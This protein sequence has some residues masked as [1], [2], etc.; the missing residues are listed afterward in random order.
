MDNKQEL[1]TLIYKCPTAYSVESCKK[2]INYFEQNIGYA[3]PGTLGARKFLNNLELSILIESEKD[4]FNLG[5]AIKRGSNG[6][7]KKYKLFDNDIDAWKLDTTFIKLSKWKP[8][9]YYEKF[10]CETGPYIHNYPFNQPI[11]RIFSWI[12]YLNNIEHGGGTEFIYQNITTIPKAGD[13]YIW[14]SGSSHM[15]RGENAPFEKKYIITGHFIYEY[16]RE[17]LSIHEMNLV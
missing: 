5:A 7:K 15:H 17:Y 11:C 1:T 4:F 8:N 12:I 16:E 14:P 6:F 9:N 10:H 3:R 2:A 13:F